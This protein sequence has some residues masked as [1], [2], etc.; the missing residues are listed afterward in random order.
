METIQHR[1]LRSKACICPALAKARMKQRKEE[2]VSVGCKRHG[3]T[4]SALNIR[5]KKGLRILGEATALSY[6]T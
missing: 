3:R 4:A 6:T 2:E 5:L 1:N